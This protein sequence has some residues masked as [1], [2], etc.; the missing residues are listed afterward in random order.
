MAFSTN[1]PPPN[2]AVDLSTG[3]IVA[4]D[5]SHLLHEWY[6]ADAALADAKAHEARLRANIARTRLPA[7]AAA[8]TYP[9]PLGNGW[10]LKVVKPSTLSITEKDNNRVSAALTAAAAVRDDAGNVPPELCHIRDVITWA[11]KLDKRAYD[12][13]VNAADPK[14]GAAF[15]AALSPLLTLKHGA[16]T[17]EI[18]EPKAAA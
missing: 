17:V 15:E 11:P 8:G 7:N 3:E 10:I 5:A 2:A 9:F 16:V 13:M 14:V 6:V 4:E 12:A 1:P 18:I